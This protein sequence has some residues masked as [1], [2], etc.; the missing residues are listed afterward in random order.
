MFNSELRPRRYEQDKTNMAT[1]QDAPKNQAITLQACKQHDIKLL[2]AKA[3]KFHIGHTQ[4]GAT[5]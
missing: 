5:G 4:N 1:V 2:H 3:H